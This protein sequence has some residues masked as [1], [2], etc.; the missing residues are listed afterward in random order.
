MRLDWIN[1]IT[2]MTKFIFKGL[3]LGNYQG[4]AMKLYFFI[5]L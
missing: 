5:I 1:L 4:K 3:R 2:L